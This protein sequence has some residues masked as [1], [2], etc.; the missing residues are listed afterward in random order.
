M[1]SGPLVERADTFVF[2]DFSEA[3]E[4]VSVQFLVGGF[5]GVKHHSSTNGVE[6]VG[7]ETGGGGTALSED[8]LEEE[9][10][11]DESEFSFTGVEE[12]EVR[13]TVGD[14]A[15]DGD[16]ETSIETSNAVSCVELGE[17]VS[18]PVELSFAASGFDVGGESSSSHIEWVDEA[19]G[20]GTGS[21]T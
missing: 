17:A 15:G 4:G 13:G 11:V 14:D 12:T 3:L 5:T 6:W 19:E 7:D 16:A 10:V 9:V 21:P 1:S 8:E 20:G 18:E 2:D